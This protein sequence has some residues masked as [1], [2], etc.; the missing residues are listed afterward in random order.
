MKREMLKSEAQQL[1]TT[2]LDEK[3]AQEAIIEMAHLNDYSGQQFDQTAL[4]A[5]EK[6]LDAVNKT[7]TQI[8]ANRSPAGKGANAAT[9]TNGMATSNAATGTNKSA[10]E[11]RKAAGQRE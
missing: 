6:H 1:G 10:F 3:P 4:A 2:G 8:E 11:Q 7:M 9:R 5:L